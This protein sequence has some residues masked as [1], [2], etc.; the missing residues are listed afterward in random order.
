ME[1]IEIGADTLTTQYLKEDIG[2][3]RNMCQHTN[4]D[5]LKNVLR[6]LKERADEIIRLAEEKNSGEGEKLL[7][8]LLSG[9]DSASG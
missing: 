7:K 1:M 5:L 3:F 2:H 4:M 6:R 9:G 8:Q